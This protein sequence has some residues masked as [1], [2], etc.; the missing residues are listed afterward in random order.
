MS[1]S[2]GTN[3]ARLGGGGANNAMFDGIGIIHTGSNSIQL[4]MNMEAVGEVKVLVSNYQAEYGRLSG[5][6]I[7]AVTKS[8]TNQFRGRRTL[9]SSATPTGTATAG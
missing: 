2:G 3:P 4:T 9:T 1:N 5:V 8:G 6:Q 7:S